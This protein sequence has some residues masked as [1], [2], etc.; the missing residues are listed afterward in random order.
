MYDGGCGDSRSIL[1]A[2]ADYQRDEDAMERDFD[3]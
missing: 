2:I 3:D 1:V